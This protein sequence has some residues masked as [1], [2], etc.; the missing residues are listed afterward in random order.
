MWFLGVSFGVPGS[1]FGVFLEVKMVH[2][3]PKCR[4]LHKSA[5]MRLE[6]AGCSGLRVGPPQIVPKMFEKPVGNLARFRSSFFSE[7]CAQSE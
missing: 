3:L 2:N 4:L 1:D 7:N 5:D 6:P